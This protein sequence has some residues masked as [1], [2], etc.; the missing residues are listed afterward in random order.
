MRGV[1]YTVAGGYTLDE[2][3]A[4]D[5][6]TLNLTGVAASILFPRSESAFTDGPYVVEKGGAVRVAVDGA[7]QT[8]IAAPSGD[9]PD[10]ALEIA[11]AAFTVPSSEYG[12]TLLLCVR[13]P[14]GGVYSVTPDGIY[15]M[16]RAGGCNGLHVDDPLWIIGS[17]Y[18]GPV[19]I[20]TA[21]NQ[22]LGLAPDWTE[23][24]YMTAAEGLTPADEGHRLFVCPSYILGAKLVLV[25]SGS[26]GIGTD[27][28][29]VAV[30]PWDPPIPW[31]SDL[32]EPTDAVYP[33]SFLYG[34]A[35]I[36]TLGKTGEVRL[37][38]D[39]GTSLLLVG[40]LDTPQSLVVGPDGN[41]LWIL[42][43]GRGRI[44]RLRPTP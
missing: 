17:D 42:E 29:A 18:R 14:G 15:T 21:D 34:S 1:S 39:D 5:E 23:T 9:V 22:L 43:R 4:W 6:A 38:R 7:L 26:N 32:P 31:L 30:E 12:D 3:V 37:F 27:G 36:L 33:F 40:G 11:Q 19:S 16:V 28:F 10:E 44:L 25:S 41:D 24:L 20:H 35:L 13:G 8:F 2:P